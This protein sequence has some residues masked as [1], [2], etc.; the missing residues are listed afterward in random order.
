[1]SHTSWPPWWLSFFWTELLY[2]ALH[3]FPAVV[4][5]QDLL[6]RFDEPDV[7]FCNNP[8]ICLLK[9]MED[10]FIVLTKHVFLV[11]GDLGRGANPDFIRKF[12]KFNSPILLL[13]NDWR[14]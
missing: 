13:G 14:G 4:G 1:M 10:P 12:G 11:D 6:A 8:A 9:I 7:N 3:V 2:S 5:I